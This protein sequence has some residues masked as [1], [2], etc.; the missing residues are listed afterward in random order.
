MTDRG[1]YLLVGAVGFAI[2]HN[3]DRFMPATTFIAIGILQLLGASARPRITE[4]RGD[5]LS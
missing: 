1:T 3:L 2:K 4:L 5:E